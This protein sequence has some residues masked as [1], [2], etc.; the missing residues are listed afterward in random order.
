MK[1]RSLATALATCITILPACGGSNGSD[2]SAATGGANAA[3]GSSNA[4]GGSS[5]VAGAANGGS[6]GSA[7]RSAEAGGDTST[8]TGGESATAGAAG[9]AGSGGS[10]GAAGTGGASSG[11]GTLATVAPAVPLLPAPGTA[12]PSLKVDLDISGRSSPE[13]TEPGYTAWPVVAGAS[14]S[15]TFQNI[16]FT[17]SKVGTSGTQLNGGWQKAAVDIP[18]YARLVGDGL[19]VDGG[20]S[21]DQIQLVIHGLAAGK[22]SLLTFH[23]LANPS[24]AASTVDIAVNGT[25]QASKLAQSIGVLSDAAAVTA[26]V[27]FTAVS[28]QDV[29][30]S[31]KAT[32]SLMINGFELDTPNRA[33]QATNPSP[34]DGDEHVDGDAGSLNLG[35]K[36]APNTASHDV[37]FG[38]DPS[39]V[40]KATHSS[41]EFKGN[42]K[43]TGYAV[44]NL[45]S[46]DHYY[47]R[48][49]EVDAQ[50]N[51]TRG[52]TW[53][54]RPRQVAFPGA[55]GYGRF[56]IGGRGGVVVHVTNL[57]DSG[58]G[59]LRD[60]IET[61]RGPR[62]VVFD[63][64]GIIPLASRL[65]L[66]QN[67]ITV[68]GQ[69]APGKGICVRA[70]PF[71]VTGSHDVSIRDVRVRLGHGQTYDGMGAEGADHTIFDH[72]SISWTI[73][74]AFSS[75]NGKNLTLQHSFISE[76]LNDA[77]HQNYPPGTEHGYAG[78]ISGNIGSFHHN[79]LAHCE[80]RNWSLAGG[81][82]ANG[83]FAGAM[84]IFDNLVYNWG[85]RTTD[86]GAHQVNFVN[87]YYRPGASSVI[88]VALKAQ[89]DNFPGTQQ[90]YFAGNVMPGHF[91]ES[92]ETDGRIAQ[93]GTGT[94]PTSYSPWVSKP[95]FPSYATIDTAEDAFKSVLSDVGANEPVLD[96]HDVRVAK[97]TLNGTYT[98]KGSLTG[99]PGLPD[100][101]TDVGG[102]ENYPNETRAASWDSDGD[103]LPDWW[104]TNFELNP[105]STKGDLS[106][107]NIDSDGNGY[108]QLEEYLAWMAAPHYFTSVGKTVSI[109]LGAA[110]TG[111][112]NAPTYASSN[113]V[114]G[115]LAISGK[116]ATFTPAKCGMASFTV[117][118]TDKDGSSLSKNVGAWIDNGSGTCP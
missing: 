73:D 67:Y 59:S 51:A 107:A 100:S 116:T 29:T 91:T 47:W 7:G 37:Y 38:Q 2:D 69:T 6:P 40:A 14:L 31:F 97:E 49:D 26:Y 106:D 55:E 53:Y 16:K 108:T 76:C 114:N 78:S 86:G 21:G 109:D 92:N 66:A 118:V 64:G 115:K 96:D 35:W 80:G 105:K 79:L 25:T 36:A 5:S 15:S 12:G 99:K 45:H 88:F 63:V 82:D 83:N 74:E 102:Y 84:D 93:N 52:N 71:G 23:N 70:A 34:A 32:K 11:A 110:F 48:I 75:R 33:E 17:F 60:A 85:G 43:G 90:Y 81:L 117:K 65:S 30:I 89:Y 19:T 50:S 87:N 112:T 95:F 44:A 58:A 46:I 56:A 9:I 13:V 39:A 54:F 62:T 24:A 28:G 3:A 8:S 42:Q 57:N 10:A 77:G 20:G 113:V 104:E 1:A 61:D 4:L 101:E 27:T 98:Y 18:N 103:G 22:H 72:V 111:Y 41:P 68:A 94:V